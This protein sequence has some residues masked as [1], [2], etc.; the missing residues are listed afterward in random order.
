VKIQITKRALALRL[1]R[2]LQAQ[3]KHLRLATSQKQKAL[4]LG[5]Y[6]VVD[7]EG[8][9]DPDVDLEKLA[10][11]LGLMQSWETLTSKRNA[12][13]RSADAGAL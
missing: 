3:G 4:G 9:V 12:A 5:R 7:A 11:K 6:Y 2:A 13:A 8:V 1:R 10:R